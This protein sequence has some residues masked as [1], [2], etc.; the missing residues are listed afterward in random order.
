MVVTMLDEHLGHF[1]YFFEYCIRQGKIFPQL[2]KH[3]LKAFGKTKFYNVSWGKLILYID[4]YY[5][6]I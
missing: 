4:I 5:V 6:Y 2:I 1:P 3:L